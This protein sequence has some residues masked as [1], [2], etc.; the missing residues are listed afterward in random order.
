[1]SIRDK[2]AILGMGCSTFGER[3]DASP[4]QLANEAFTEALA[5][6]NIETAQLQ[7]A[8]LATANPELGLGRSGLGL[9]TALGLDNVPVTRVENFCT[10]GT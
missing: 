4:E 1:M 8:W 3:W 5:D 6:A 7:A 10:G 2:V 9:S